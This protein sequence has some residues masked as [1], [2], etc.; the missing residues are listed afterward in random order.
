MTWHPGKPIVTEAD[1]EAW[2]RWRRDRKREQQRQRRASHPRIDYYPDAAALHV[3]NRHRTHYV[4][5]DLSSI[6][7]RVVGEWAQARGLPPPE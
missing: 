4:G 6:I 7:N 5:G 1:R 3:I 2:Q